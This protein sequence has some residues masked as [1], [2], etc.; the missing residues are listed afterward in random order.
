MDAQFV[1][2]KKPTLLTRS[3]VSKT[4]L[5]FPTDQAHN[6]SAETVVPKIK[7]NSGNEIPV[8]G[9]GTWQAEGDKLVQ[10]IKDG[11]KVGFRH[12]DTAF[13]FHNEREIAQALKESYDEG[14]VKRE[15]VFITYKVWP[16][17]MNFKRTVNVIKNALIETNS[18]YFDLVSIQWPL[19]DNSEIYRALESALE[20]GL[21][22]SI[23]KQEHYKINKY[24][25]L[26]EFQI[27]FF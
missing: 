16:K 14:V 26:F 5:C 7:L 21:T 12:I 18:T 22:R 11:L 6:F 19:K 25:R 4:T 9:F 1:Q 2:I 17:N 10:A 24:V 15:D 13:F 20:E 3:N 27:D 8:I 23:G